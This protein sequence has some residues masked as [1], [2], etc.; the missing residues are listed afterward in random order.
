MKY[1]LTRGSL[2]LLITTAIVISQDNSSYQVAN[3]GHEIP[4]KRKLKCLCT[5]DEDCD[6][7]SNTCQLTHKH[8]KCYQSWTL[9]SRNGTIHVTAGYVCLIYEKKEI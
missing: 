2:I 1:M 4:L 7:N 9:V 5:K 8:H 6:S 3:H